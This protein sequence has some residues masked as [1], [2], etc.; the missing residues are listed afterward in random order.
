MKSAYVISTAFAVVVAATSLASAQ[1]LRDNPPG[2]SYQNRGIIEDDNGEVYQRGYYGR[3]YNR[4]LITPGARED[5][6]S[7]PRYRNLQRD[8]RYTRE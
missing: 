3:Q 1:A 5:F 8:W 2:S 4:S 6:A 7:D